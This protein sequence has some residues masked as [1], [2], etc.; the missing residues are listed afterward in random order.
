MQRSHRRFIR[1]AATWLA[2][3]SLTLNTALAGCWLGQSGG[4]GQSTGCGGV[5]IVTSSVSSCGTQGYYDSG[6]YDADGSCG[7]YTTATYGEVGCGTVTYAD[8]GCGNACGSASNCDMATSVS[9]TV[10]GGGCETMVDNGGCGCGGCGCGDYGCSGDCGSGASCGGSVCGQTTSSG[11]T[12]YGVFYGDSSNVISSGP[13]VSGGCADCQTGIM[14]EAPTMSDGVYFEETVVPDAVSVP[15]AVIME[16]GSGTRM[17]EEPA[18]VEERVIDDVMADDLA[19]DLFDEG[20]TPPSVDEDT[21]MAPIEPPAAATEPALTEP[22]AV[23]P[24]QP[25]ADDA[26]DMD[27]F[28]PEDDDSTLPADETMPGLD[29]EAPLDDLPGIFDEAPADD[30]ASDLEELFDSRNTP[31]DRPTSRTWVDNTGRYRTTGQLVEVAASH[32]RLL[33]ENGRTCTVPLRR[34]SDQDFGYVQLQARNMGHPPLV[35]VA[36]R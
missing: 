9:G 32:I 10:C 4:W 23:E 11:G 18:V 29:D 34:L 27:L 13:M 19:D 14:M 26:F 1:V 16:E 24:S 8:S 21:F 22:P 12:Y 3:F 25:S 6:Y 30:G 7:G 2:I 35:R 15:D 28:A 20:S 31:R 5:G 33:K 17:S 36:G